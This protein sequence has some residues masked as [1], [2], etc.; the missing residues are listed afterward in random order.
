MLGYVQTTNC[1]EWLVR[2]AA[3][4]ADRQTE[5]LLVNTDWELVGWFDEGLKTVRVSGRRRSLQGSDE[6]KIFHLLLDFT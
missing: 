3:G 2:L 6:I 5:M 4:L 1:G